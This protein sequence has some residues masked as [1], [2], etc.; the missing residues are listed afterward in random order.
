M[1][2]QEVQIITDEVE[3]GMITLTAWL[4]VNDR[5]EVEELPFGC[6]YA[7][8]TCIATL[9]PLVKKVKNKKQGSLEKIHLPV[10]L[11]SY[12]ACNCHCGSI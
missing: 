11:E 2:Y 8:G 3:S 4:L 9:K 1:D 7:V 12:G 6:I 5:R 10:K